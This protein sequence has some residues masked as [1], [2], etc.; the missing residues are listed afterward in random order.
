[1]KLDIWGFNLN[2]YFLLFG[3]ILSELWP[4][5]VGPTMQSKLRFLGSTRMHG[6]R[7][8]PS[9]GPGPLGPK[10]F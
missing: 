6:V 2:T 8:N 10:K 1:M 4:F 3:F 7:T 5:E 9:G